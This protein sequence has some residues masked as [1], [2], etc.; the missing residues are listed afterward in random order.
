MSTDRVHLSVDDARS[1]GE[2]ALRGI[3]YDDE[4]ARVVDAQMD[5]ALCGYEYSGLAK[6]LNIPEHRRFR[7]P[8]GP[9]SLL[10]ETEVSALYDGGNNNGMLALYHVA[11]AT[12]AKA[13]AHGIALVGVTN[14]WMSGRNAYFVEM[15]AREGFVAIHT[16]SSGGVGARCKCHPSAR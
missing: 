10:R 2:R 16:A 9:I 13:Q 5:A 1:L 8:R 7:A 12:I 4:E 3:G 14:T 15:I 6:L 11:K